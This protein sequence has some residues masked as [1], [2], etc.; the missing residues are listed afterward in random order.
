MTVYRY[1]LFCILLLLFAVIIMPDIADAQSPHGTIDSKSII[2]CPESEN[3]RDALNSTIPQFTES[4]CR[5][6]NY[7]EIDP[8]HK[9]LWMRGTVS[10][11]ENLRN[12]PAPLAIFISGKAASELYI[13][14][15]LIG[16]NGQP[17]NEKKTE[18]PGLMDGVIALPDSITNRDKIELTLRLSGHHSI[19]PLQR[20][21]HGIYVAS[22]SSPANL[23]LR[24]YW[25]SLLTFGFFALGGFYFLVTAFREEDRTGSIILFFISLCAA[26]QLIAETARGLFAYTYPVHDIRL[27]LITVFSLGFGA[28][29]TAH[30]TRK[31]MQSRQLLT[32]FG[33]TLTTL[34]ALF[35]IPSYD[36]KAVFAVFLPTI[37]GAVITVFAAILH[38]P[39][40]VPYAIA[41]ML[42]ALLI[43]I[44][45][46]QFLNVF[47]FYSV[48]AL[49]LFLF[50][51]QALA[52]ARE[53][54]QRQAEEMKS[55]H[56][57]QALDMA[58]QKNAPPKIKIRNGN[59]IKVF[60]TDRII[61][62][63]G[64]GDY[65]EVF[66]DDAITHLH[67]SSLNELE[68]T[69]PVNFLRVHRSHIVNTAYVTSLE[70]ESSGTGILKML[71]GQTIPVS[72]RIMP[73]VRNIL[74]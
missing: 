7:W 64:A 22:Y 65:V 4:K 37:A 57:Q 1:P 27:L 44:K 70:R 14:G 67:S 31:F 56:L 29:L 8:Q 21:L 66:V 33:V 20:P 45:P 74:K 10:I 53:Q 73:K 47:F 68:Q 48:A 24:S 72:R 50:A 9:T 13:D 41:L 2:V 39:Q 34:T 16:S 38:R 12:S 52:L 55:N 11:P 36:A 3:A 49:L 58:Q 23:T 69:L 63:K 59:N 5:K 35:L 42:F 32:F 6:V 28:C 25:P 46:G 19:L 40:A 17:A 30:I 18:I 26:G 51:Q 15:H 43:F 54:A 60:S 62:F 61:H 71:K